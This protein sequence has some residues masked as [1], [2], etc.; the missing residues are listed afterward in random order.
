MRGWVLASWK[1]VVT[2]G[3]ALLI[4]LGLLGQVARDRT[5]WLALCMYLP[6]LPLGI[7]TVA[8][9]ALRRGRS[10]PKCRFGLSALGAVAV[11]VAVAMVVGT[12]PL[13]EADVPRAGS[14][15]VVHWNV[16]WGGRPAESAS[17]R[18]IRAEIRKREPDLLILSEAPPASM[19]MLL[20][21][22]LGPE[23]NMATFEQLGDHVTYQYHL[24]I[25]ARWPVVIERRLTLPR[26]AAMLARIDLPDQSP[27]RVLVVDLK[28]DPRLSRTPTLHEIAN[29]CH[30]SHARGK[31]IDLVAGDMNSLSRSIGFDALAV[32]GEGY[33][34]ASTR[35]SG[36]RGTFPS[37]CPL[38]DIDHIW[39]SRRFEVRSCDLF[40]NPF[41]N[42]RGQLA[43]I[44][45]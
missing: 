15:R 22:Q 9:D 20:H 16:Q 45:R 18:S 23:W 32:A 39:V 21:Q 10:I 28:S 36:W 25:A 37:W 38:Y 11:I 29:I 34:L 42:H 3:L 43:E 12:G 35:A 19:Q 8:F 5:T 1:P 27:L 13:D 33:E 4:G 31:P 6:L 26:G 14:I 44:A 24:L 17:W 2:A 7:A 40:S 41:T 30:D